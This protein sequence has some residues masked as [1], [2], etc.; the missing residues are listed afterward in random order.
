[1][2]F[3]TRTSGPDEPEIVLSARQLEC[4][5]WV[6]AGKSSADIAV[7]LN[8]SSRTVDFHIGKICRLLNVRT[9]VQ[10]VAHALQRGWIVQP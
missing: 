7:I 5:T 4:L 9:R 1:M 3:P 8:I 6:C 2:D 10:A